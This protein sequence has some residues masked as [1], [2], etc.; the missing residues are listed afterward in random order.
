M[1]KP[2][3]ASAAIII[4]LVGCS[5]NSNPVGSAA[6]TV[7]AGHTNK[8]H[9]QG[10]KLQSAITHVVIIVQENRSV[11]DLFQYL[12]GANTQNFG[13]DHFNRKVHL[14][15]EALAAPFDLSHTHA[16]WET[17]YNNGGMNGF[18]EELCKGNCPREPAYDYVTKSQV[19]EY[20]TLAEQY[21]FADNFFATDQGPSFPSHQYLVSG[22]STTSDGS[23]NKASNNPESPSGQLVGGCDAPSGSLVGVI[24]PSGHEPSALKTFPCFHRQSLMNELDGAGVSWRYYQAIPESGL[25]NAVDAIYSIWSNQ[26]EMA[27]HVVTPP[28]Q[29]LTDISN[30]QLP[31]VVWVTPTQAASD[32]PKVNDGSGP[33]WVGSIVN[34]I[35][36]S[37]YW[38]ST[39][40]FI[41]WDDWGGFYDHVSPR[42]YNSFELGFR[43]PLI[44]VSP[45]AKQGYV[46]HTQHEF[47]SLLK[48]TEETFDLPSLGTTDSRADDLSDCFDFGKPMAR[49]RPIKTHFPASYFFHLPN[50]EP[51]D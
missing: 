36:E 4:L 11:D 47:G 33:S 17:E 49:F 25:F 30:A 41:T 15:S 12:R 35:G 48:F 51:A 46:S 20:Y 39:A 14:Q 29:V 40:I 21:T 16:Y 7:I 13:Y 3:Y 1:K 32:H 2:S 42:I 38:N 27:T 5:Q 10:T 43:V 18:D 44:V 45:Y 31:Q 50:A 26:Y 19:Q 22:T 8:G 37:Q 24:D 34:A 9:R 23:P 28:T 6:G